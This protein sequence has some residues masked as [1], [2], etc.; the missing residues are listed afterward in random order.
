KHNTDFHQIV[1]FL[2]ASHI[3]YALTVHPT[4]NVSHIQQFWSTARIETTNG[5]TKIIAKVN[6]RQRTVSE[7]SIRRHLKLN[8]EEGI[9]TLPDNET[10][11]LTGD[12]RYGEA[13]H[14]VTRLDAGQDRKKLLRPLPCPMKHYQWL[15][16]LVVLRAIQD[17]EITQLKTRVKTLEDNE[18][19]REGF[20]QED[21][22]NTEGMD[23]GE[24]L[25]V[26]DTV[27]VSDKTSGGLRS[28]FTAASLLV[29]TASTSVSPAVATASGSFPTA[30]IFTTTSVATPTTRVIRF[31][32]GVV[33]GSSSLIFVNIPSISKKDKGKWKITKPEQPSK[34]KVLEQMSVQLARDL[35]AKFAQEDQIIREQAKRDSEIARI[36][37]ESELKMMIA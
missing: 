27:K 29:A 6:D 26:E 22:P 8:D 32:R 28:V 7:L 34:E 37:A 15:L 16:L 25:L 13:F 31:S 30:V 33:I 17:L 14:T 12:I 36:Y 19:R 10:A 5:E 35:E 2:E 18:R 24:D 1:D 3:R 11:F 4:V 23:Q 20:A 9:S 21:A